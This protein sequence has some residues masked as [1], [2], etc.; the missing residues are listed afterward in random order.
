M[1]ESPWSPG[2]LSFYLP[3]LLNTA[4]PFLVPPKWVPPK[5]D[6]L[7]H[8]L[9]ESPTHF[10]TYLPPHPHFLCGLQMQ[11]THLSPFWQTV[12]RKDSFDSAVSLLYLVFSLNDFVCLF[13]LILFTSPNSSW[14]AS[15]WF[16]H[17]SPNSFRNIMERRVE[18]EGWLLKTWM[19]MALLTSCVT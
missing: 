19:Q 4:I 8:P 15:S 1:N 17:Q 11:L 13:H 7:L 5:V 9:D 6:L 10:S 14:Q 18:W 3:A 16:L 2:S 12:L